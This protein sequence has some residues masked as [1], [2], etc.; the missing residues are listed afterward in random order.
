M[1]GG[2]L[3]RTWV[4]QA[5]ADAERGV[6]QCRMC[7]QCA[8]LDEAITLWRNGTLAF[9]VC[10]RCASKHDILMTPTS[11]GIEIRAKA[12]SPIV[13]RGNGP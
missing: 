4:R 11:R 12:Q 8:D 6:I 9:A 13:I 3:Q 10:D 1:N 7:K 5:H 2:D